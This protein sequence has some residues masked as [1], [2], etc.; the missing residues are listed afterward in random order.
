VR[1]CEI[2]GIR[3]LEAELPGA[4]AVFSTRIGGVSTGAF[5]SLNLGVLTD[6]DRE[7]VIENR[8]RL[9]AALGLE[10]NRVV[11][12]LQIHG[13]GISTHQ[14]PQRPSPFAH[15]GS[16]N[17]E[18][19][20]HVLDRSDLAGLVFVADCLPIALSGPGGTAI[21]HCGWRGLAAGIVG[22]GSAAV[23]ARAAAIGPGIGPCCYQVGDEVLAEFEALGPGIASGRM[24]DLAE[25]ARRLLAEAGVADVESSGLCTSCDGGLF[26]SHRRDQG[27][28]G[29]QAG[30]AW[31]SAGEA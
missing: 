11:T 24:L 5:E 9:C 2:D 3:W 1:W 23:G 27:T 8:R 15:P 30:L 19:D 7:S 25:V 21:L 13:A 17:P 31:A 12:G 6:D 22:R 26:F 10:P 4:R 20:G 16:P 18:A 14:G 29:R 28:T